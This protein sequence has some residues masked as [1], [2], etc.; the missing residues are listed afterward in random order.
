MPAK[1]KPMKQA[2]MQFGPLFIARKGWFNKVT[3]PYEFYYVGDKTK[4][5]LRDLE[6]AYEYTEGGSRV[7]ATRVLGG[8]LIAG[9]IGAVV[10]GLARK[11]GGEGYFLVKHKGEVLTEHYFH[12]SKVKDARKF[13]RFLDEALQHN[14]SL[15][16]DQ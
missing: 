4:Y 15:D 16:A 6:F 14:M 2:F 7:T 9:P 11:D 5:D 8:A 13:I 1:K 12:P 3:N 10:G